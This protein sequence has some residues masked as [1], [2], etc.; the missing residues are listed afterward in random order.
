M[1]LLI[2]YNGS[3]GRGSYRVKETWV[4]GVPSQLESA[5]ADGVPGRS[6]ESGRQM[7]DP[8]NFSELHDGCSFCSPSKGP[9]HS[10][11]SWLTRA[12]ELTHCQILSN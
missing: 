3:G 2:Y 11:N 10:T 7:C 12:M 8:V 5:I 4:P 1:I 6:L 9:N